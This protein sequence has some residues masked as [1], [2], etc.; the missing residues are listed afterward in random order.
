MEFNALERQM[1]EERGMDWVKGLK[2]QAH[3]LSHS[4][5]VVGEYYVTRQGSLVE[6][7]GIFEKTVK[8]RFCDGFVRQVTKEKTE[9]WYRYDETF[10]NGVDSKTRT[11]F[12][13]KKLRRMKQMLLNTPMNDQ[14]R[15]SQIHC[16]NRLMDDLWNQQNRYGH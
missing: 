4:P 12:E 6:I 2:Q 9:Y 7:L 8:V 11:R 16:L 3:S 5:L 15:N 13:V 10:L 1:I 14:Q